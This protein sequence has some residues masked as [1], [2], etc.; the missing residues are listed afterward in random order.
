MAL[1]LAAG[2]V[3]VV[4]NYGILTANR[5]SPDVGVL[6]ATE[7]VESFDPTTVP[8]ATAPAA[9]DAAQPNAVT[10]PYVDDHDS[11]HRD[12]HDRDREDRGDHDESPDHDDD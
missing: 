10:E 11:D 9:V 12:D 7:V 4:A 8:S 5:P 6:S 1:V 2:V 3:A